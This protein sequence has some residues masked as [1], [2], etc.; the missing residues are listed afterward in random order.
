MSIEVF[1]V[2]KRFGAYLALDDVSIAIRPGELLALL[3]P[4]GC[5][6]TSLLR[7]IAGLEFPDAGRVVVDGRDSTVD[8][9]RDRRVGLVLQ[10]YALF[11]HLNVFDNVAF[12]LRVRPRRNRPSDDEIRRRVDELLRLVQL[13]GM[14]SRMPGELSGGQRQ[15]VALA[16]A[17]AIEPR[18][19]LLDEPFG[20]LDAKVRK[21]LRRWLRRLHDELGITTIFVT[22]DQEEALEL[23]DRVVIMNAG[24]IEQT[25]TPDDVYSSPGSAFVLDFLGDVNLFHARIER[26]E[27]SLRPWPASEESDSSP[28]AGADAVY[29]RPHKVAVQRQ[30]DPRRAQL[31]AR[32]L[33]SHYFG[34]VVK[35]ELEASG[36][37]SVRAEVAR[38]RFDE[39]GLG[40]G[41]HVFVTIEANDLVAVPAPAR[42]T[43]ASEQKGAVV[44]IR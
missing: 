39:L 34:A 15:R 1:G 2:S 26:G 44:A 35:L 38:D 5:G 19:L 37:G 30:R 22:H 6:K 18:V 23:A 29:V 7:V 8:S 24:R 13:D 27:Y 43:R 3:G 40:D 33:R 16:R 20:A 17:L 36:G 4:S 10:H 21:D 9:V 31:P 12:G 14:S 42:Q 11:R 28:L 32:I 25:G 41:D